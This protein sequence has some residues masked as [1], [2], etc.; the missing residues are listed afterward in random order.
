LPG[1]CW[2]RQLVMTVEQLVP[3]PVTQPPVPSSRQCL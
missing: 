3:G 2:R 1:H